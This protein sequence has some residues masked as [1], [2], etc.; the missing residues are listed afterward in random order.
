MSTESEGR[1]SEQV[2]GDHLARLRSATGMTLRQVEDATAKEVSNAYLSQLETGKVKKPSPN[3]LYAL[4]EVYKT[5]YEDL[6]ERAGY[7][8]AKQSNNQPGSR[9]AA[10]S[11]GELSPEEETALVEYL[12]FFRRQQRKQ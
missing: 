3:I 10:F 1:S 4:S 11:V 2:F 12:A 5:P 9:I 6:M 8:S 7:I